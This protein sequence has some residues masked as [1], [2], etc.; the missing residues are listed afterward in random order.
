MDVWE[1]LNENYYLIPKDTLR[2][3]LA[4]QAKGQHD[5]IGELEKK[6]TILVE[7]LSKLASH[8]TRKCDYCDKRIY[9]P[10]DQRPGKCMGYNDGI[11][12]RYWCLN[13]RYTN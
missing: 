2:S 3:A 7:E 1:D 11:P 10:K 8:S 5:K 12:C 6:N 9:D 13:K 4:R